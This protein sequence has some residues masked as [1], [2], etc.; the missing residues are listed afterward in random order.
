MLL[1]EP[2]SSRRDQRVN[3]EMLGESRTAACQALMKEQRVLVHEAERDE[4][5]EASGF[6]LDFAASQLHLGAPSAP[7][8]RYGHNIIVEVEA[9]AGSGGRC[10]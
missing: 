10:G 4:L 8:F 1:M 3:F 5:G 6:V 7:A 9:G 2:A